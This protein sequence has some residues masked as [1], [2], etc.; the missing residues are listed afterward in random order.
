MDRIELTVFSSPS[1]I[2]T[3]FT[4]SITP[5]ISSTTTSGSTSSTL[6]PPPVGAIVGG[7]LGALA[8]LIGASIF[9]Y[10]RRLRRAHGH[11]VDELSTHSEPFEDP[12]ILAIAQIYDAP[13]ILPPPVMSSNSSLRGEYGLSAVISSEKD[14]TARR[15]IH[16]VAPSITSIATSTLP[17]SHPPLSAFT[18][19]PGSGSSVTSPAVV[20]ASGLPQR[21]R[22]AGPLP[23]RM[24][25]E[26]PEAN[27]PPE[28]GQVFEQQ[29]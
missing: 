26:E 24:G 8:L 10:C 25:R 11:K 23:V 16:Q 28:Y 9:L 27:L 13:T 4:A 3:T 14:G 18:S 21:E 20:P 22:D 19:A 1:V 17:M 29:T 12:S 15:N 2:T 7:V 5:T 6:S